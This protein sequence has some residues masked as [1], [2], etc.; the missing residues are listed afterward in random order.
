MSVATSWKPWKFCTT[1]FATRTRAKT[2]ASGSSR[3]STIRVRSTQ[4]LP[5]RSVLFRVNPRISA[6]TIAM[7]TA[8]ETKFCTARPAICTRWPIADSPL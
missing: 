5:T 2:I 7:P 4:K 1:P 8:A 3:R 6:A